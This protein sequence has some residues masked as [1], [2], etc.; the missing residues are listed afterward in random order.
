MTPKGKVTELLYAY[1]QGDAVAMDG[2]FE[3]VYGELRQ[4]AGRQLRR[5]GSRT[6]SSA[7]L[8]HEVYI[9]LAGEDKWHA[10]GRGH[11]FALAARV[12][13]QIL[14]DRARSRLRQKRGGGLE[15]VVLGDAHQAVL[16]HAETVL[17][18]DQALIRLA[19]LD[20][21]LVR[22]VECRYF[23]GLSEEE[24]AEILDVSPRTVERDWRRAREMLRRELSPKRGEG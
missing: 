6:M 10:E 9:K 16:R 21:R 4:L 5:I 8:V 18:I 2:L 20:P 23:A 11:F 14:V 7:D 15:R 1:A 3:L 24:T 19:D 22:V 13:R 12:M 17:A